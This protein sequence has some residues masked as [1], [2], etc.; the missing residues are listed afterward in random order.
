MRNI[1]GR[2]ISFYAACVGW[3]ARGTVE[4]A[5]GWFWLIGLPIFA[6]A[7][8]Y[9]DLGPLTIPDHPSGFVALM[10]ITIALTWSVLFS[11]RLFVSPGRIY[12][13]ATDKIRNLS[14]E[15]RPKLRVGLVGSGVQSVQTVGPL[16][17]WVQLTVESTTCMPLEGCEVRVVRI[18]K[19]N[20]D[21]SLEDILYE[22]VSCT[23]S[24]R[25]PGTTTIDIPPYVPHAANLFSV[26][27]VPMLPVLEPQFDHVKVQLHRA[28]QHP[29]SYR[30]ATVI[31]AKNSAALKKNF[32]LQWNG[33]FA[34]VAIIAE[35]TVDDM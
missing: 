19:I 20:P 6:G 24:Q 11:F 27:E 5:N 9:F 32:R 10:F 18:Q 23:W 28:I 14:N 34:D 4:K 15:L 21:N 30:I 26:L 29:G 33:S 17:K 1:L 13:D 31:L 12:G 25:L 16:S 7:G 35:K 22:A 8:Y 2:A 3:S